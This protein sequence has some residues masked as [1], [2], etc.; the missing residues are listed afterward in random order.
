MEMIDGGE[1]LYR[2]IIHYQHDEHSGAISASAFMKKR[3]LDPEVSVYLA[4]LS[5]PDAILVA[6]LPGQMLVALTAQV[7]YDANLNVVPQPLTDFPGHCVIVG[8]GADNWKEQCLRL[9]EGCHLVDLGD[10]GPK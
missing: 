10:M 7:A 8:F 5:K 2:R 6:G 4:R 3:K 1:I 9:A